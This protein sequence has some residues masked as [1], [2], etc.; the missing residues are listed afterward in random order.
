MQTPEQARTGRVSTGIKVL[1]DRLGGGFPRSATL[2]LFSDKPTEK[3]LFAE[4]F[5]VQGARTN[6]TTVYVDFYRLPALARND[7]LRFGTFPKERLVLVDAISSQLMVD[8]PE[9]YRI[10]DISSLSSI[11]ETIV[12]AIEGE[13]PSRLVVD[14]MEFLADRFPKDDVLREWKRV[15]EAAKA[16]GCVTCFLFINWTYH[17]RDL[18]VIRTMSDF[19]VEFQSSMRGGIIR[20]SMRITEMGAGGLKTNWIPYTFKDLIGVTVYFPRILVTG[21]F[22]A[23]KST[24][25]RSLA[26]RAISIDRMGTTVAFDYGNVNLSG[27]EAEIFGTPG[28]ERFE[29]IFKIFAREVSGVLLVVDATRPEDFDRAKH[30]LELIGARIPFVVLANKSDLP[31]ALS[32]DRIAQKMDLPDGSPVVATVATENKGLREALLILAEMIIGVR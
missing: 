1:D 7:L 32:V 22:N 5:A 19:L 24:V 8:S 28:Q 12:A 21:P 3:R 17:E 31:G 20:S 15:I 10:A 29:F 6:E 23:G 13:R 25:V 11:I 26:E 30:M 2:L 27:I 14:S 4:G 18:Q 9:K 16:V